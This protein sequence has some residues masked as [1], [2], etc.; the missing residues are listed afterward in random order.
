MWRTLQGTGCLLG[1]EQPR[2]QGCLLKQTNRQHLHAA[3]RASGIVQIDGVLSEAL[4]VDTSEW[5][6]NLAI[7]GYPPIVWLSMLRDPK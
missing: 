2:Q 6:Q 5:G 3:V 7:G 1:V 4:G